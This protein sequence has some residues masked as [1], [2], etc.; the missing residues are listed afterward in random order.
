[1]PADKLENGWNFAAMLYGFCCSKGRPQFMKQDMPRGISRFVGKVRVLARGALA[2]AGEA[3]GTDFCKQN[4]TIA[5]HPKTGF[6]GT[7]KG[8]MKFAE[9]NAVYFH[10]LGESLYR[11]N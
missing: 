1:M 4:A 3:F 7:K 11:W 10:D 5:R 9:N 8:N 6:K 2:P